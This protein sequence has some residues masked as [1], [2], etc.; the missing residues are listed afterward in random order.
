MPESLK[1]DTLALQSLGAEG[2]LSK[3]E[4]Q[5]HAKRCTRTHFLRMSSRTAPSNELCQRDSLLRSRAVTIIS[6]PLAL[7]RAAAR[8]MHSADP[9][10]S[11]CGSATALAG[12]F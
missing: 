2:A 12:P 7:G 1:A 5:P 8:T 6:I 3:N 4:H 9:P 11:Y 10:T